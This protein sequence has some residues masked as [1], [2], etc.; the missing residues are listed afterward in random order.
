MVYFIVCKLFNALHVTKINYKYISVYHGVACGQVYAT[1]FLSEIGN[2]SGVSSFCATSLL[3]RSE[4]KLCMSSHNPAPPSLYNVQST[5]Y[6]AERVHN[7]I[8]V[9]S[10]TKSR[11]LD[12]DSYSH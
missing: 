10:M 2:K 9:H 4:R 3:Y 1:F 6:H 7:L 12:F 5:H 8:H 11:S